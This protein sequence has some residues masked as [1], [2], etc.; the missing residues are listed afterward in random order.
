[1]NS[2]IAVCRF[3]LRRVLTPGRAVW[4]ALVVA[5]P[6]VITLLMRQYV[7]PPPQVTQQD[8]DTVYTIALY[9]LAPSVA[10]MLGALLMAAPAVASELEQH[11]WVYIATRP[12]GLFHLI[13]GK[14]LVAVLWSGSATI[15]GIVLSLPFS[16][17]ASFGEAGIALLGLAV[18]SAFSYSA[19]YMM[20]GT[21]F[22]QRAM[23]F[24]VAYTG[25]VELFMGFFPAVINRLTIQYRLRSLLFHWTTQSREFEDSGLLKFVASTEGAA[26]QLLWLASFTAVFLSLA[27]VTVQVRE[28][29]TAI[30]SDV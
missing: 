19:L 13:L 23:V 15:T 29:T 24:C 18:L 11:S 14:F 10:C 7:K 16:R 17:I 2:L 27:L 9:F 1:M 21:V 25:A 6:V 3:E 12:N 20:I 22:P 28:F 8:I 26:L 5:F 30:E 4:W